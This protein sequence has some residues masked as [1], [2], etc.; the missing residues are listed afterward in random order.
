[1]AMGNPGRAVFS[2]SRIMVCDLLATDVKVISL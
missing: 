1:M 2:R